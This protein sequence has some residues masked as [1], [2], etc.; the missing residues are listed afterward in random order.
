M[1]TGV[2]F[3]RREDFITVGGYNEDRLFAEDVDFLMKMR[4]RGKTLGQKL[5]RLRKSKA[6]SS[7]RKFDKH[8][9][10]HYFTELLKL[11]PIMLRKPSATTDWA[12]KYWYEDDR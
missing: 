1:D 12:K 7:T 8:G 6:I 9:D 4:A 11:V 3:C 2:V 10:W 5:V